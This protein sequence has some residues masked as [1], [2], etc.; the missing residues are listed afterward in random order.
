MEVVEIPEDTWVELAW[1][2]GVA[3][4]GEILEVWERRHEGRER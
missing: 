1:S 3:M 4:V 2:R